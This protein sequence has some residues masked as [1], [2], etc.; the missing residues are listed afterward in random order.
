[1]CCGAHPIA[2][3]GKKG[4]LKAFFAN[5]ALI[6]GLFS[7]LATAPEIADELPD[8]FAREK[9]LFFISLNHFAG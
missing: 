3:G 9:A 8:G 2:I 5:G 7:A 6:S 1:M 4:G